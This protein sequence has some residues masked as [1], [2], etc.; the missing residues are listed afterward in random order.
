MADKLMTIDEFT[1]RLKAWGMEVKSVANANL[2]GTHGS[3]GLARM[4]VSSGYK[5]AK[6][7]HFVS[8][9]FPRHG[10]FLEYGVGRGW[11]RQDGQ[12][13]R[14]QRTHKGDAIYNQ[15]QQKG[16]SDK[17][18]RGY[19][20][21]TG[22]KAGKGR[23][24]LLWLDNAINAKAEGIADLAQEYYGDYSLDKLSDMIGRMAIVKKG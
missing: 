22:A 13:V 9:K 16:Y 11:I 24:P 2:S 4:K 12:V 23:K 20:V 14:G 21:Q 8:F 3:G 6:D 15:L 5:Q 19:A 10:V 7:Y 1:A 18:I 17:E